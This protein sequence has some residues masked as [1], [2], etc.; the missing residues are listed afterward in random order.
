MKHPIRIL[1]ADDHPPL[2]AGLAAILNGQ[3]DFRVVAEAG[4]G[5][6][7]MATTEVVDFYILDLRMPDGDG[8]ATI[9]QLIARDP[10]AKIL[11]LTT[12]DNEEDIFQALESGARGY[13]LKDTTK[14]ELIAAVRQ[15]HKG[16]RHLSQAVASRLADRLIRPRLTPRELDVLR[17]VSRGRSN[18]EMAAA[19][20]ISEETVK[21]H[22]KSL[23]QKLDVH[24][25][26]E[27]VAVSL[28]RG[29]IRL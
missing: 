7:V 1:L 9:R 3:P 27:A 16:E 22:M 29:L 8:I 4:S 23:F 25:R 15:I 12:Y 10:E 17:L 18:K 20:F 6:E 2:R 5:A 13:L 21:T 24:D 28:Q 26:A 11:V 19:M 14:E